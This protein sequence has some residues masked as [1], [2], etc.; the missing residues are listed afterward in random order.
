ML[1]K[2]AL[3]K[4]IL[5]LG[6]FAKLSLNFNFDKSLAEIALMSIPPTTHP[7]HPPTHPTHPTEKVTKTQL[8][9]NGAKVFYIKRI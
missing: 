2:K 6:I 5:G 8:L 4:K 7:P 1:V 3:S 9:I